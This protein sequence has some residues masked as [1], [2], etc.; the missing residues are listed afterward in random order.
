MNKIKFKKFLLLM[1][2]VASFSHT[3][4]ANAHIYNGAF[5]PAAKTVQVLTLVCP[6]G[7]ARL[8]AQMLD[9]TPNAGVM[10]VTV[11]KDGNAKT[12]SDPVQGNGTYGAFATLSAGAG[13]YYMIATQTKLLNGTYKI[14]YHCENSSG[15]ETTGPTATLTQQ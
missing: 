13:T 10:S 11:F 15:G 1:S 9:G 14:Q 8:S 2:M 5:I 7:S 12:E 6:A 3:G 4:I